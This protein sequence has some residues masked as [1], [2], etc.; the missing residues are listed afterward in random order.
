MSR[1]ALERLLETL[2]EVG[3]R[4]TDPDA[5]DPRE[6][7]E[8]VRF[9]MHL[10]GGGL[11][12]FFEADPELPEFRPTLH[13]GRKFYGDNPDAIYHSVLIRPDLEYRIRASRSGAV[14]MS[15]TVECGADIDER[16][17][18]GRAGATRNDSQLE[19]GPDGRFELIA[20]QQPHSGNW[21]PLPADATT[22]V[23]RHYFED[24]TPVDRRHPIPLEIEVLRPPG[25]A[26]PPPNE[27]D[28]AAIARGCQRVANFVRGLSAVEQSNMAARFELDADQ[29]LVIDGRYPRCRFGSFVLWNHHLQT[30]EYNLRR[31]SLNRKQTRLRPDGSFRLVLSHDDPGLPNWLDT[32]G[33]REGLIF[34]RYLL[35][36]ERPEPLATRVVHCSELDSERWT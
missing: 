9:L 33:R 29:A 14:Y 32:G 25:K 34:V 2:R 20:S 18:P 8:G 15:L 27:P 31:S 5:N 19:P 21:L 26:S 30:F 7:S 17:P 3:E 28:D 22:I 11:D 16:Y 12:L 10:L 4:Y 36:E 24:S 35:P 23:S 13:A 1:R 6:A